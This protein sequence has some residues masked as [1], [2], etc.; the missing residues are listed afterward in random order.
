M[1]WLNKVVWALANPL[2]FGILLIVVGMLVAARSGKPGC[3]GGR[4]WSLA[5]QGAAALWFWIWGTGLMY[6]V[7]GYGLERKFPPLRAEA[8][9]VADAIVVLGGG[10]GSNTNWPYAEMWGSADRV[11]HAARLY[12]ARKAPKVIVS[13]CGEKE[14][15]VPLL[16]D[17]GVPADCIVVE[18]KAGNTEEN[19]LF[20]EQIMKRQGG[21]G[22]GKRP[23]ILLVTSSWH[24]RR[25]LLNFENLA[26]TVF[27]AATDHEAFINCDR[28]F[29]LRELAPSYDRFAR[30]CMAFKEI[31][32][33]WL[34]RVKYSFKLKKAEKM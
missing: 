12:H 3:R 22:P 29:S 28:P 26:L 17:L 4:R 9:P 11:W 30:N 33:Y 14:S 6:G 23:S 8:M 15:S 27:P 20:V 25:A 10:M 2:T 7:I 24:M 34:Y 16:L 13:G 5:I 19:A 21:T 18:G 31:L 1:I 32:G